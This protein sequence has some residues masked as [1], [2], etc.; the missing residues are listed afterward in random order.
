MPDPDAVRRLLEGEIDPSEIE[1]DPNLYAMAE[2]I[3]GSE[4]LEE[5]G[6]M[7]PQIGAVPEKAVI[8]AI[9]D[10]V[11]LPDFIPNV[12]NMKD[13]SLRGGRRRRWLVFTTGLLGIASTAF[14]MVV[15]MG[16]ALCSVGV[17]NMKE[18]CNDDFGQTKVVWTEGY[19]FDKLHNID[20]W[21]RP[22][23][24]P[25]LGDV[26]LLAFFSMLAIFGILVKKK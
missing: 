19:T 25:L 22:M 21:V 18:I 7:G 3:Y 9:T 2:R 17:A 5:M 8:G 23:T 14:N 20:T 11:S 6:V 12:P 13:I 16:E 15:G 1:G 10:D 4:A 24:E 26:L